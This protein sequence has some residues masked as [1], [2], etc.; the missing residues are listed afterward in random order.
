MSAWARARGMSKAFVCAGIEDPAI[1]AEL[2][3]RHAANLSRVE[4]FRGEPIPPE[5]EHAIDDAVQRRLAREPNAYI[6]G[7][8]EF[9]GR[10]F[11]VGPAVL[12]PRPETEML[13]DLALTEPLAP[14][15]VV[16]DIGTGSGC[17]AVSIAVERAALR[18]IGVDVSASA[19]C[20]ARRN[21]A[22]NFAPV[23][24]V[25]GNV[26]QALARADVILANLPYI[27]SADI[28]TLQPEVREWEPR[29]ALDGGPDG[30]DL[31]RELVLDC[32]TRLHPRLL[33]MEVGAGQADAVAAMLRVGL[34]DTPTPQPATVSVLRDFAGIPRVVLARWR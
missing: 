34:S 22:A 11:T 14:G 25:R 32:A 29:Q 31:I 4:Y 18:V 9:F 21:A 2:L 12:I 26:S 23:S 6:T 30:L 10:Q 3:V 17:I 27:P 19:L 1:E 5:R 7:S 13:V 20:I 8:Q 24:F 33:A 15:A 28:A 16:A